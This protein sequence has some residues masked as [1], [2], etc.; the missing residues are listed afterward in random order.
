MPELADM[1]LSV[2]E[3]EGVGVGSTNQILEGCSLLS[4]DKLT[5]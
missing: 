3:L 4:V 5:K 2:D 1:P